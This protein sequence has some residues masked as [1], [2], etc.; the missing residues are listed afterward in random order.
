MVYLLDDN[1]KGFPNPEEA[2]E[3]GLI[4]IGG[5]LS[6]ERLI[7]AYCSG[8]F[9]WFCDG[10]RFFWFSPDP[11][12]VLKIEDFKPSKSLV[13][14]IRSGKFEVRID[15]DFERLMRK[16]AETERD[17]Q[18]GTWI[19]EDYIEAYTHLHQMGIAHSFETYCQ[20]ELVG[21]LYGVSVGNAFCGESMFH[22]MTDAS[23]VAFAYMVDYCRLHGLRFVDAQ[24]ETPHLSSL[25]ARPIPRKEFLEL[26]GESQFSRSLVYPWKTNTVVFLIGGNQ[27][28]R[29]QLLDDACDLIEERIGMITNQS[30][31]YQTAPWGDFGDEVPQDFLNMALVVDT[32][33]DVFSVLQEA[34]E[35]EKELGRIRPLN[36]ANPRQHYS[37]RPIDIDIIFFN[38]EI[39][40][41][42]ELELPHPRMQQRGFVLHPLNEIMPHFVHPVLK[43]SIEE[44]TSLCDDPNEV[45]NLT[46]NRSPRK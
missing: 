20:G 9:P 35:I 39:H 29:V 42:P 46:Q 7:N 14:T 8:I 27:G 10:D 41:T 37:S 4:A 12:M 5:D 30:G 1:Y 26:L 19:T 22:T 31:I 25:G 16:C 11:R 2:D 44:L 33:Q 13:R 28:D 34:L 32:E 43:K 40:N 21:G 24:Q 36:M 17:D 38:S 15:T 45:L 3:D 23:K 6:V 18:D